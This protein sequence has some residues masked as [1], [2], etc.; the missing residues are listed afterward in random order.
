MVE[1]ALGVRVAEGSDRL[2]ALE[3][4]EPVGHIRGTGSRPALHIGWAQLAEAG[5][6]SVIAGHG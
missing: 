2:V 6:V 5:V 1:S 3:V 4:A